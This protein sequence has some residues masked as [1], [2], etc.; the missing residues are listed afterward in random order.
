MD[1]KRLKKQRRAVLVLL[2]VLFLLVGVYAGATANL[3]S[4]KLHPDFAARLSLLLFLPVSLGF[5]WFCTVD[6]KLA[7]KPLI[8]LAKLGIF[9][10]WPVGVPLYLLWARGLRGLATLVLHGTLLFL[11][12]VVSTLITGYLVYGNAFLNS[13][14]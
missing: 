12:G 2:Y 4:T 3:P 5:M 7:G 14:E 11:L 13:G 8:Q 9:L 6:A 1:E 10:G